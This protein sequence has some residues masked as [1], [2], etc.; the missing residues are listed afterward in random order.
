[1]LA[2]MIRPC[3]LRSAAS[4]IIARLGR[5]DA[6]YN[7]SF[8]IV[9]RVHR[10]T[11]GGAGDRTGDFASRGRDVAGGAG[12]TRS[13]LDLLGRQSFCTEGKRDKSDTGADSR[14]VAAAGGH[15]G[16]GDPVAPLAV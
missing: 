11:T 8:S 9:E 4:G 2:W 5:R 7:E 1:M 16:S 12:G 15:L 13:G 14:R 10:P 6:K 3:L